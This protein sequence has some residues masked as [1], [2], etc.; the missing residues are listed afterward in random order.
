MDLKHNFQLTQ[1]SANLL[2][3]ESNK[4]AQKY[5]N[6]KEDFVE[7]MEINKEFVEA[8][9]DPD[10]QPNAFKKVI[11]MKKRMQA[12]REVWINK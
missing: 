11:E 9:S 10:Y 5:N 6:L 7:H 4:L 2:S 12:I 3:A 8:F 1:K